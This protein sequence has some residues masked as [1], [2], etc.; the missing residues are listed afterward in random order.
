MFLFRCISSFRGSS[1]FTFKTKYPKAN[2]AAQK[3]TLGRPSRPFRPPIQSNKLVIPSKFRLTKLPENKKKHISSN[4]NLLS[5]VKKQTFKDK[6]SSWKSMRFDENLTKKIEILHK[7]PSLTQDYL[8]KHDVITD[9]HSN[10]LCGAQTGTGKT[11]CFLLPVFDHLIKQENLVRGSAE[12]IS[13][14][15][16]LD[17]LDMAI[18][19]IHDGTFEFN[20]E[21]KRKSNAFGAPKEP[22][23]IIFAPS[24]QL[25][26]QITA[27]AKSLHCKLSVMGVHSKTSSIGKK[28]QNPGIMPT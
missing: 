17:E 23:A 20:S 2:K 25:I 14:P 6:I 9:D 21:V 4:E 3:K 1:Q 28:L 24:R 12:P 19:S 26:E 22:R 11:L 7:K 10:V 13:A 8:L 27:V 18:D 16:P 15:D 5:E